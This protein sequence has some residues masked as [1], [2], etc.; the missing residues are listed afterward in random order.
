MGKAPD[1]SSTALRDPAFDLDGGDTTDG[2]ALSEIEMSGDWEAEVIGNIYNYPKNRKR[3]GPVFRR[4]R[5]ICYFLGLRIAL[6]NLAK[7][8]MSGVR[9]ENNTL[10][11]CTGFPLT[12]RAT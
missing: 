5:R 4:P 6:T 8:K 11:S 9:A 12:C 7:A 3:P 10:K 1:S 2:N